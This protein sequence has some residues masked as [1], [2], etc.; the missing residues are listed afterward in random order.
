VLV[1]PE[2]DTCVQEPELNLSAA[3]WPEH[4][5]GARTERQSAGLRSTRS[6][7]RALR[8]PSASVGSAPPVVPARSAA[9]LYPRR[10]GS[11]FSLVGQ[12][13]P[14]Y[15]RKAAGAWNRSPRSR[16]RRRRCSRESDASS[17]DT[18]GVRC[19][20]TTGAAS[21][22]APTAGRASGSSQTTRRRHTTISASATSR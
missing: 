4:P 12:I 21:T 14:A 3:L 2:C 18:G 15:G 20:V 13:A 5:G 19:K 11:G 1:G 22:P 6:A 10:C 16:L 17:V 9:Q 8:R 7:N